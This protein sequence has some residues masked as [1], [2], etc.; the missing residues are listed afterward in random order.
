MLTRNNL[1][2]AAIGI[3]GSLAISPSTHALTFSITGDLSTVNTTW[4]AI[5]D[6]GD[7]PT[8]IFLGTRS[9]DVI[10]FTVDTTGL[11]YT[12]VGRWAADSGAP[13]G[14]NPRGDGI[15]YLYQSAFNPLSPLTNII[16][17]N[18]DDFTSGGGCSASSN[19]SRLTF[20]T[21]N[22]LSLVTGTQYFAVLS[23]FSTISD[24]EL[25][26]N[27]VTNYQIDFNTPG[28]AVVNF[29]P[30]PFEFS[31]ALGVGFLGSLWAANK[32]RKHLIKK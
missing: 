17:G 29:T 26:N 23:N 12:I 25:F 19:C 28:N 13:A 20:N 16:S 1:K 31:P 27:G 30:V 22:T 5:P 4:D 32:L 8:D 6:F 15:L 10:P 18:D 3:F 7:P 11:G 21:G 14:A 9:Y 24:I 2:I